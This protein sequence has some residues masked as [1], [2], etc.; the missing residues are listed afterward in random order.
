MVSTLQQNLFDS[1]TALPEGFTYDPEVFLLPNLR[2]YG[3]VPD[4][5]VAMSLDPTLKAMVQDLVADASDRSGLFSLVDQLDPRSAD[6]IRRR[7]GLHDGRQA[8]LADIG[9]VHGISAE[10]VRQIE[11]EALGRLRRLA[12][13]T[14]AA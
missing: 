13:P 9:A 11:R 5:W 7:Y 6:V 10:R 2:G 1:T 14:L 3:S 12:D 8:K 4:L